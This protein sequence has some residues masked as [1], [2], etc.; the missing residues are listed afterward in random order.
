VDLSGRKR[1]IGGMCRE[2]DDFI[3]P[4]ESPLEKAIKEAT[5]LEK[6]QIREEFQRRQELQDQRSKKKLWQ[7]F[8]HLQELWW[9]FKQ[10]LKRTTRRNRPAASKNSTETMGVGTSATA[11]IGRASG[12]VVD[13]LQDQFLWGVL[14]RFSKF[15][16]EGSRDVTKAGKSFLWMCIG[17]TAVLTILATHFVPKLLVNHTASPE[18]AILPLV[19]NYDPV[20]PTVQPTKIIVDTSAQEAIQTKYDALM[21]TVKNQQDEIAYLKAHSITDNDGNLPP[22][23]RH[24]TSEQRKILVSMFKASGSFTIA[25]RFAHLDSEIEGYANELKS[26]LTEGGWKVEDA[27]KFLSESAGPGVEILFKDKDH[28]PPGTNQLYNALLSV[29]IKSFGVPIS[30]YGDNQ[31]ELYVG[32]K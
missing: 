2:M 11:H 17:I 15:V 3:E 30:S 25:V 31:L 6:A 26:V 4:E 23:P 32:Y 16:G 8:Y 21:V 9:R 29:G 22:P 28:L 10:W 20:T 13:W 24:L 5:A 27:P 14:G 19:K 7:F 12:H 1:P 18:A